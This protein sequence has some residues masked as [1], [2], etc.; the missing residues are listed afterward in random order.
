MNPAASSAGRLKT[1]AEND[2]RLF[3]ETVMNE[4][5]LQQLISAHG[6]DILRFCRITA[7]NRQEGDDLYQDTML[8][9]LE[10]WDRL[11]SVENLKSYAISAAIRLWKNRNRKV[12]RRSRLVPQES[13]EAL[14]EQ[15][16]HLGEAAMSPE[17]TLLHRQQMALV[18]QLVTKLPEK[19]RLPVQ[20]YYS[21]DLTIGAI[22]GILN[23]PENTVK[24]RLH[25]AKGKIKAKLEEMEYEGSAV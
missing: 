12:L 1:A 11:E 10:K 13:L 21:A 5:E 3:E 18:R 24:S 8:T 2:H 6:K 9:L 17:E 23:L 20:L 7:G 22:A 25:R 19:Y 14:T 16:I 4:M 15:G